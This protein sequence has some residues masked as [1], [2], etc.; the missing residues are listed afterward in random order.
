MRPRFSLALLTLGLLPLTGFAGGGVSAT[1]K[2]AKG[3]PV[4]DAVVSL[5]PLDRPVPPPSP[6]TAPVE[7]AQEDEQYQP[8]MTVVRTGTRVEFPNKDRIQH[9]I[10]SASEA[11]KFEKP[12][13]APGAREAIVFDQPGVVALGCNIHDWMAAY[14]VVLDTPWFARSGAAGE[15]RLTDIPP[16]RY[17]L[18]VWHP[19]QLG[20]D[21]RPARVPQSREVTIA[22]GATLAENLTI[23]LA[24]ERRIR[25]SPA[26]K[27]G[28]Y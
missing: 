14:V 26:T 6:Q 16:G 18:D 24:P 17:R 10:Y 12:L 4:P 25:R 1:V 23:T 27:S 28:N 8:F 19:R 2:N 9:H 20:P 7:V 11:K 3:E 15:A 22:E 5:L 21:R 13:Y